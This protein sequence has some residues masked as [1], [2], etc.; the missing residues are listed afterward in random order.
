MK[1]K[2]IENRLEQDTRLESNTQFYLISKHK[3]RTIDLSIQ[4]LMII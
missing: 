4:P 2:T 1:K 3:G